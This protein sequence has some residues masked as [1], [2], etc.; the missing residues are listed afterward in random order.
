MRKHQQRGIMA[1][2]KLSDTIELYRFKEFNN[3]YSSICVLVYDGN[4]VTIKA[5]PCS[6]DL[7][8][9]RELTAHIIS[10][11]ITECYYERRK[12]DKTLYKRWSLKYKCKVTKK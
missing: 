5:L 1:A 8:D 2:E 4:T 9:A 6:I 10:K 12:Q 7:E 3:T 11:G